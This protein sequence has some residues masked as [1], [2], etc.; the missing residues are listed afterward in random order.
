MPT[1]IS[2]MFVPSSVV[3]NQNFIPGRV[4][5]TLNLP[6]SHYRGH[7]LRLR[8]AQCHKAGT[9]HLL[10]FQWGPHCLW[11]VYLCIEGVVGGLAQ[12]RCPHRSYGA[13]SGIYDPALLQNQSPPLGCVPEALPLWAVSSTTSQGVGNVPFQARILLSRLSHPPNNHYNAAH[14]Q[15]CQTTVP[16]K[17][18]IL[19]HK[20]APC[21]ERYSF[22]VSC[23]SVGLAGLS[24]T[25]AES[26]WHYLAGSLYKLTPPVSQPWSPCSSSPVIPHFYPQAWA[27]AVSLTGPYSLF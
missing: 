20:P 18:G 12:P 19:H 27:W 3:W 7:S 14:R 24:L 6:V 9:S 1:P 4:F 8:V 21:Y 16:V 2:L 17:K 15:R 10:W 23:Y 25:Q 26:P 5:E 11:N 22:T 13:A